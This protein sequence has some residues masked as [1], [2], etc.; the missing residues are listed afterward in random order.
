M[1]LSVIIPTYNEAK[2]ISA[3]VTEL[4]NGISPEIIIADSPNSCDDMERFAKQNNCVYLQTVKAGRNHQMN[5]AASI[6]GG[7]V[8]YFVHA[9][10]IVPKGYVKDIEQTI[11]N[12][13][14]MGCYRYK[15]DEYKNPLLR[16]NSFFTRF[17]MLWCRGGDQTLF[18]KK[19]VFDSL[20]GYCCKHLIMEDYDLLKRSQGKYQFEIIPKNVIVSARKYSKNGYFKVQW[21]NF[22]VMRKW[23]NQKACP[24]E[25][26]EIYS[27]MLN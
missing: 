14:D 4:R 8:L 12:G 20:G 2:S 5:E 22:T 16:I 13:A 18:I 15:F 7:D 6:A 10:T 23:L 17:P 1:K 11:T 27:R 3:C 19:S 9:D 26:K 25:L 24:E 21:A